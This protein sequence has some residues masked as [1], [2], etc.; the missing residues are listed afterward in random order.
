VELFNGGRL[1][2]EC[3]IGRRRGQWMGRTE[4]SRVVNF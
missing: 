1:G 3:H 2:S 4:Y